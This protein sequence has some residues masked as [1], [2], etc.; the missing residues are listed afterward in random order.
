MLSSHHYAAFCSSVYTWCKP[1]ALPRSVLARLAVGKQRAVRWL[2]TQKGLSSGAW[3]NWWQDSPGISDS[4]GVEYAHLV[5]KRAISG[6]SLD[7]RI[8]CS[9]EEGVYARH[10]K[11]A[12][13]TL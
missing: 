12:R 11:T 5:E 6:L 1:P 9:F 2:Y 8:S 4:F 10:G 3:C 7:Q 13:H